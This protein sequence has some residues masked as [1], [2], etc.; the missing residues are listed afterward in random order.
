MNTFSIHPLVYSTGTL[1]SLIK[2]LEHVWVRQM[3]SGQGHIYIVSG[4][5][6]YNGGVR[7]YPVFSKHVENGGRVT[8]LF[9]G[10]TAQRL[11]SKQ[12]VEELLRCGAEVQIVNRKRLVH[13]KC[14]GCSTPQGSHLVVSSGNF[15]GPGMSQ[16]VEASIVLDGDFTRGIGFD[17]NGLLEGVQRQGWQIYT[18]R[19]NAM[20]DPGWRLLYDEVV[21]APTLEDTDRVS[22]VITLGHADT[23]RINAAPGTAAAR[24]TQYFWLSRDCFDFFPPLTITNQRGEKQT[25][26]CIVTVKYPD[27]DIVDENCRVTFEAENN[28]DFRLGTGPLRALRAADPGDLA[29]IS[30]LD[31]RIYD[32]R[33]LRQGSAGHAGIA[34]Y[35]VNFIGHRGKRYGFVSNEVI[36]NVLNITL[37]VTG[38]RI[39]QARARRTGE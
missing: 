15:T 4:F 19:L 12:V 6:N 31:E 16:N 38:Q 18:P 14:Y 29:V 7:F 33:I 35:A 22:L 34:P 20:A 5:G 11:T 24:G 21:G 28:L 1:N 39:R 23:I 27:L 10:S 2:M 30:R 9:A 32:L 36:E 26:S 8:A 25:F 17:W 37:D 13:A 3:V